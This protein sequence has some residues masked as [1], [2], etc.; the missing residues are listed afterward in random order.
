VTDYA[1][2]VAVFVEKNTLERK[3]IAVTVEE[4]VS[5]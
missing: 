4:E 3:T 5:A 2:H 1:A